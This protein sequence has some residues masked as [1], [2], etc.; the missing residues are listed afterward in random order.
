MSIIEDVLRKLRRDPPDIV[1]HYCGPDGLLGIV[2]SRQI[3]ATS[4]RH[5]ND[6]SEQMY[7]AE[8]IRAVVKRIAWETSANPAAL[9]AAALIDRAEEVI[10]YVACFS[11][12]DD[13]LSQWR[14][15]APPEGGFALGVRS[16]SLSSGGDWFFGNCEYDCA[17]HDQAV[18]SILRD[19]PK[20]LDPGESLERLTDANDPEVGRLIAAVLTL[21]PLRK[22]PGFREEAE[23]RV[24]RGPIEAER[25]PIEFRVSGGAV[26]PYQ[27]IS[28]AESGAELPIAEVVIGPSPDARER[29][30][31]ATRMLLD[32]NG[33]TKCDLRV[34]KIPYRG[35]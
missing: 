14:A 26:I 13:L 5:L 33:L 9:P 8:Q 22:H 6:T 15:Y 1:Y 32:Q 25:H 12:H 7:A 31:G 21:I 3:W 19:H 4:M 27:C 11:E 28:L 24:V 18:E 34:S 35:W 16:S 2:R 23:W 30:Y 10:S 20:L 29:T 17:S